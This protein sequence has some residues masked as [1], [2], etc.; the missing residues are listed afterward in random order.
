MSELLVA[1]VLVLLG[2]MVQ[3]A[4]G[5]GMAVVAAPLLVMW[6]PAAVPGPLVAMAL[7]QCL[8]MVVRHRRHIAFAPLASAMVGRIP[9]SLVGAWLLTV[10]SATGLSMF[11]GCAVLL[12]VLASLSRI[13]IQPTKRSMFWAGALSGVLGTSTTVGGP[14]MAILMQHQEA[15]NLRGNLAA[16]FI[17]GCLVSLLML[18]LIGRFGRAE[19]LLSL[20]LL[21]WTVSGYFLCQRLPLYRVERVMRPAILALCAIAGLTAIVSALNQ[22][23][24]FS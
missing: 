17:Y 12:A 9:G 4:F 10:V 6:Y 21:P 8:L 14:P 20:Y 24:M 16:F 1:G 7:V 5:F 11:V 19:C 18:A 15:Q 2:S 13:N 3:T 23:A 22:A